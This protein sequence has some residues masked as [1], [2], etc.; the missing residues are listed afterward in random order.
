MGALVG[1]DWW[2]YD[3]QKEHHQQ[4]HSTS[5]D[6]GNCCCRGVKSCVLDVALREPGVLYLYGTC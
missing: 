1:S 5:G 3:V 6:Y 2:T 4:V